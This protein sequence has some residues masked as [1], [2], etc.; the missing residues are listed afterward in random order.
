MKSSSSFTWEI[1]L[2][3]L[4]LTAVAIY[5]SKRSHNTSFSSG[6]V[7]KIDKVLNEHDIHLNQNKRVKDVVI[8]NPGH[9]FNAK[10][11]DS[12]KSAPNIDSLRVRIKNLKNAILQQ[13]SNDS[14]L[15]NDVMASVDSALKNLSQINQSQFRIDTGK[16]SIVIIPK[17]EKTLSSSVAVIPNKKFDA[18]GVKKIHMKSP[19]GSI[20]VQG[21][22]GNSVSINVGPGKGSFSEKNFKNKYD[23]R[24]F[25][26]GPTINVIINKKGGFS[27]KN[28]FENTSANITVKVPKNMNL[29]GETAGGNIQ[30][31]HIHGNLNMKTLGGHIN[32]NDIHGALDLKT[33]GGSINGNNLTGKVSLKTLGGSIEL[34]G[35]NG[36]INISTNGGNIQMKNISGTVT[37]HTLGGNISADITKLS[38]DLSFRTNA[39][40]IS[41][42]LPETAS[43]KLDLSGSDISFNNDLK[44]SG[45]ISKGKVSGSLNG[46]G[47]FSIEAHTFAGN[48]TLKSDK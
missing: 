31:N 4:L 2:A 26:D 15:Q 45:D 32:L 48:I 28:L 43:A 33:L 9:L 42:S 10:V 41:I 34:D 30:I 25:R 27:L 39:G 20:S 37:A 12:L 8:I 36:T 35:S 24:I 6:I 19:G 38:D 46:G 13:T 18:H 40:N 21:Y 3:G 1:V 44:V 14:A 17:K 23:V 5:F 7:N 22:D 47:K 29:D 11:L 16:N